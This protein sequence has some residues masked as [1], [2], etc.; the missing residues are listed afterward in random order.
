MDQGT[1]KNIDDL[2]VK[3]CRAETR[4]PYCEFY[5][6]VDG[7]HRKIYSCEVPFTILGKK[8]AGW[9]EF[10]HCKLMGNSGWNSANAGST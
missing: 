2:G 1:W 6:S 7:E 9:S 4:S 5:V 10:G 3:L 8:P